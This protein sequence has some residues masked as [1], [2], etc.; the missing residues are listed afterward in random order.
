MIEQF[1][2]ELHRPRNIRDPPV[3]LA[4][5]EVGASSKE[6]SE[7]RRY[8]QIVAEIQPRNFVTARVIKREQQ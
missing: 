8:D 3:Q 4:I 1:L 5:D 2:R 6:Q 7:R